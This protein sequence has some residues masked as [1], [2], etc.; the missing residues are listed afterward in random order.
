MSEKI[1]YDAY[2]KQLGDI[3]T[4][5]KNRLK[6]YLE[7]QCKYDEALKACYVSEKM[8]DCYEF[9]K[10]CYFKMAQKDKTNGA[11]VIEDA[12]GYKIARDYFIE[13]L[14]NLKKEIPEKET[15]K[16]ADGKSAETPAEEKPVDITPAVETVKE[17]AQQIEK[18][19]TSD[20]VKRDEYGFEVFG[21]EADEPEE[22][23]E[24][25]VEEPC[26][27]DEVG[28]EEKVLQPVATAQIHTDGT[29][30]QF[31]AN[32]IERDNCLPSDEVREAFNKWLEAVPKSKFKARRPRKKKVAAEVAA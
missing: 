21:E 31:Y 22:A 30:G 13:I 25:T 26:D 32:E 14:P 6:A 4:N 18:D 17:V 19:A 5:Q 8:D 10:E 29:I 24:E 1:D 3:D 9:F 16:K 2:L 28:E 23:E 11:V 12:V 27:Q 15:E 7:E 20:N